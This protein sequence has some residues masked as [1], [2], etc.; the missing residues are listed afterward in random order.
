MPTYLYINVYVQCHNQANHHPPLK[1]GFKPWYPDHISLLKLNIQA[2][3]NL[4]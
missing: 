4:S 3:F 1:Y 2:I